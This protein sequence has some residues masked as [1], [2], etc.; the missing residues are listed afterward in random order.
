LRE[1]LGFSTTSPP[2]VLRFLYLLD[3]RHQLRY[4][5]EQTTGKIS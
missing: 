2:H 4:V 5:H 1:M 3:L